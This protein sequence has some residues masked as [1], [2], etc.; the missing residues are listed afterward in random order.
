MFNDQYAR[1]PSLGNPRPA[2]NFYILMSSPMY[3]RC[4]VECVNAPVNIAS[5]AILLRRHG[6]SWEKAQHPTNWG[7]WY[8]RRWYEIEPW[9][10]YLQEKRSSIAT[11]GVKYWK[12]FWELERGTSVTLGEISRKRWVFYSNINPSWSILANLRLNKRWQKKIISY[13][14]KSRRQNVTLN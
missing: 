9:K 11:V 7:T 4:I 5:C 1:V 3:R 8:T 6:D 13:T 12:E 2:M 14:D 10:R